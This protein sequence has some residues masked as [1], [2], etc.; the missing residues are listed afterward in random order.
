[1]SGYA[2]AR[3]QEQL[4]AYMKSELN[5]Q[6]SMYNHFCACVGKL[7]EEKPNDA[8]ASLEGL[9]KYLKD[10]SFK[11]ASSPD[12]VEATWKESP[13]TL[14]ARSQWAADLAELQKTPQEPVKCAVQSFMDDSA[15]FRWAGVG[16]SQQES[17]QITLAMRRLAQNTPSLVSLRFWGKIL[18]T[19][20]DYLVAEGLVDGAETEKKGQW[21]D[22]EPR[23]KG[24]NKYTY[25]V[26]S[27]PACEW[28]QL[29]LL[30]SQHIKA[31]RA[32]KRLFT[33]DPDRELCTNPWFPGKEKHLLR[34]TIG[35]ISASC[36]LAVNGFYKIDEETD[37][38]VEDPD[39][40]FPAA[41]ELKSQAT[42]VHAREMILLNGRTSYPEVDPEENEELAK[43]LE[44]E[45]EADPPVNL[46]RSIGDDDPNEEAVCRGWAIKVHGDTA[47]YSFADAGNKSYA[48]TSVK[49]QRW[50]GAVTVGQGSRT[51]NLYVGYGL[52]SENPTVSVYPQLPFLPVAPADVMDEP[53]DLEE[54]GEPNPEEDDGASDGAEADEPGEGED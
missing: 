9:S 25:W 46:H 50:P 33:G 49:S 34:A 43:Q 18:G 37:L 51:A 24:V 47:S 31:A 28:T 13:G 7:L 40:T 36:T 26:T 54:N 14:D 10:A 16:F 30:T 6:Q 44:A 42:W 15:M 32:V 48:V 8:M 1:M 20:S 5:G 11:G 12:P 23:G 52:K 21:G 45:R 41:E 17:Y 39:F 53:K 2:T 19:E 29:P 3:T 38:Q 35:R 27:G 4:K 22:S